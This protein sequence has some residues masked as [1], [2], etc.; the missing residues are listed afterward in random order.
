MMMGFQFGFEIYKR[1]FNILLV[2]NNNF[3]GSKKINP[4]N[5][6]LILHSWNSIKISKYSK[7][8]MSNDNILNIEDFKELEEIGWYNYI[9]DNAEHDIFLSPKTSRKVGF[10]TCFLD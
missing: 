6:T 5:P 4:K 3:N 7:G 9:I 2:V 1:L 10:D 8:E